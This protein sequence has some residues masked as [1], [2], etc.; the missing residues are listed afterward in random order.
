NERSA[1]EGIREKKSQLEQLKNQEAI[2]E[3]DGDLAKA[4]QIM[5]GQIPELTKEI[6][7]MTQKLN[8][9]QGENKLL[10]EEVDADDVARIVSSWTGVPVAKMQGSE[11][12]KYLDLE[13][14]LS[15]RVIGQMPAIKA[16]AN[17]IRRNKTG[18][19]D[20]H[21][22]LGTFLFAG[23]TGVGKT[24]LAKVLAS[25]LFD[26][27]KALTRIDM[28]EYMEKF[29]VSRLIGA[30]PGYVGYEEGGQLTEVVRRRPYSVVLFDEIEK[31]HPDVFN[32][33]LQLFDDGRLTDGQGRVV[34]FTNTIII[35]TSNLGSRDLI[36]F[37]DK[38]PV[39]GFEEGKKAVLETIKGAFKPEFLNRIDE[40]IVFNR[41]GREQ[42]GRIAKIQLDR[43][44]SRLENR[45]LH[46]EWD[47]SVTNMIADSGFDPDFGARPVKRAVQN[48]IEDPLAVQ[49]LSGRFSDGDTIKLSF[50]NGQLLI[51]GNPADNPRQ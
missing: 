2:A 27:E 39:N 1:I 17:A 8:Q 4:A 40:I 24:E 3:R 19:G 28:S 6:E 35:M 51:N 23:P 21:R 14:I 11:M 33:L 38:D 30:P 25:F 44:A 20:E 36:E 49:M 46:L 41:L 50:R 9:V 31:A 32:V 13:K 22:P 12:Q 7:E 5:H 47:D 26:D 10:R 45:S 34:D 18:I 37:T 16:V 43:L 48:M 42:I 29:S 15:E